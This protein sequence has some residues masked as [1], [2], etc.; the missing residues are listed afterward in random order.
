VKRSCPLFALNWHPHDLA[1]ALGLVPTVAFLLATAVA[2]VLERLWVQVDSDLEAEKVD[3]EELK[4]GLVLSRRYR[5]MCLPVLAVVE[6]QEAG[7]SQLAD[8]MS[9]EDSAP[10]EDEND[11]LRKKHV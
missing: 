1:V 2:Q 3:S 10:V 9:K 7:G 4:S 6:L 5:Q 8:L 11:F